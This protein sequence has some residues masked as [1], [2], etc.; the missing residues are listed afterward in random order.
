MIYLQTYSI[1]LKIQTDSPIKSMADGER[2]YNCMNKCILCHFVTV[3]IGKRGELLRFLLLASFHGLELTGELRKADKTQR[4][5]RRFRAELR[6]KVPI[7]AHAWRELLSCLFFFYQKKNQKK[8][9]SY[10]LKSEAVTPSTFKP[11]ISIA[12][13]HAM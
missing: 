6:D 9:E 8:G 2:P 1:I 11:L 7:T 3:L 13:T 5:E 10:A 12:S 4:E